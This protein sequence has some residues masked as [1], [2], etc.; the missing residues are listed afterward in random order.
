MHQAN[1][2]KQLDNVH[3]TSD[4]AD[5][6]KTGVDEL[7]KSITKEANGDK[8]MLSGLRTALKKELYGISGGNTREGYGILQA[9][10]ND[11]EMGLVINALE[12]HVA[13]ID[14]LLINPASVPASKKNVPNTG[15]GDI[16]E[17]NP[18]KLEDLKPLNQTDKD[19]LGNQI[20][21]YRGGTGNDLKQGDYITLDKDKALHYTRDTGDILTQK[22]KKNLI[23][24]TINTD[25]V[26]VNS[27]GEWI[28]NPHVVEQPVGDTNFIGKYFAK[29]KNDVQKK[30]ISY[31]QNN[32]KSAKANYSKR[33][34]QEYGVENVISAD[35]G[36]YVIPGYNGKN[37]PDYH[38]A[39]SGL[40]KI[41]YDDKLVTRKGVGNNTVLFTAGGTGVGKTSALRNVDMLNEDYSIIYDTNL[42]GEGAPKKIQKAIDAGFKVEVVFTQRDPVVAFEKGV[43]PRV[44]TRNRIVSMDEHIKRHKSAYEDL[45][46][47]MKKFGNKVNFSFVDNTRGQGEAKMVEFDF[48][49]KFSYNE[50]DLR[51]VLGTKLDEAVK[52]GILSPEE[53]NAIAGKEA[54]RTKN[55]R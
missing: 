15:L 49:P 24:K 52:S 42:T 55:G 37:A 35:E 47:N 26:S 40:A 48:L 28:Y 13:E 14:K 10:K 6:F 34:K 8:E 22:G 9:M 32:L 18:K 11:P 30:A 44:K 20:K 39:A 2:I 1:V 4:S 7:V 41:M 33:A 5:D 12:N 31:V 23:E 16:R 3:N 53:A 19:Y 25:D 45:R 50:A 43:I 51:K 27:N 38:E 54:Y 29:P 46:A 36:K 17:V 21:V